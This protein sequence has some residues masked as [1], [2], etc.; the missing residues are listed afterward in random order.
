MEGC[1]HAQA[2]SKGV[3]RR[4]RSGGTQPAEGHDVKQIA[5]DFG[6]SDSCLAN[7][8]AVADADEGR[9]AGPTSEEVSELRAAKRRIRLLEQ[10][11]EVLRR[12]RLS[13]PGEPAP[14]MIYPLVRE[15]ADDGI[16]VTVTCRVLKL[17]RQDYYRWL[18]APVTARRARR[19]LSGQRPLRRPP[20]R[21]RVRVSLLGRRGQR[22]WLQRLR[23]HRVEGL[24][25][26]RLVVQLRQEE[27]QKEDG[28]GAHPGL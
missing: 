25:A 2:L 16:P 1:R 24:L 3:P 15:L 28:Q 27:D 9:R 11:N 13:V 18:A 12:P 10:E 20:R 17:V 22:R 6:I 14:K 19:G 23:A 26:K 8:L 7:W 21:S 5:D 4:R